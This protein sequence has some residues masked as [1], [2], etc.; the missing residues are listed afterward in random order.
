MSYLE[1]SNSAVAPAIPAILAC[2]RTNVIID[3]HHRTTV[4]TTMGFSV[5]PVIFIDYGHRDIIVNPDPANT[6][7]KQDVIDAANYGNR[8]APKMTAHV[9]RAGNGSLHPLVTLSPNC[10]LPSESVNLTGGWSYTPMMHRVKRGP[11]DANGEED[12]R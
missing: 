7:T 8:M 3:G 2:S 9:V 11:S 10:A 4:L 12:D 6:I 5:A 1:S